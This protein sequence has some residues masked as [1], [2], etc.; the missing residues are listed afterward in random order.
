MTAILLPRRSSS[1]SLSGLKKAGERDIKFAESDIRRG[2]VQR[3]YTAATEGPEERIAF[4]EKWCRVA[5]KRLS[6]SP[7]AVPASPARPI[8]T[9][10]LAHGAGSSLSGGFFLSHR[11]PLRRSRSNETYVV[12]DQEG[13]CHFTS[14]YPD[15]FSKLVVL[16][17]AT[18]PSHPQKTEHP[19]PRRGVSCRTDATSPSPLVAAPAPSSRARP[20]PEGATGRR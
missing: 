2:L 20:R 5:S 11:M 13:M 6:L 1:R 8:S 9:A 19:L 3:P 10:T 15:H 7:G 17:L 4:R 12:V 18:P 14:H 16:A